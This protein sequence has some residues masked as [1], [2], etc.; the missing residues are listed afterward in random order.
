MTTV[1]NFIISLFITPETLGTRDECF[2]CPQTPRHLC[3][4]PK[5]NIHH[6]LDHTFFSCEE[7]HNLEYIYDL[8]Q[9]NLSDAQ[10][11]PDV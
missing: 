3:L 11:N 10:E 5:H 8:Y 9:P 6:C 4:T 1:I 2:A 7:R